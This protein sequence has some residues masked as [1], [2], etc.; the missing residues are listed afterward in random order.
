MKI[1]I[2]GTGNMGGAIIKGVLKKGI[3]KPDEIIGS[4]ISKEK[5][6]GLESFKIKTTQ[7]NLDVLD[8]ADGII[9]AVKPQ[10][11][12]PV[13]Q[14]IKNSV[15]GHHIISIAAGIK[16]AFIEERLSNAR[17]VRVMP[18]APLLVG[19]GISAIAKGR[20]TDS[21][22]I[23]FAKMVF[24]ALGDVIEVEEGLMN[25]VTSL[26]GSGPA[27]I[28]LIIDSLISVG[29]KM[30]LSR[31]IAERL[32]ISTISGSILMMKQTG[33]HPMELRDMVTS[34]GGTTAQAL[35]V[36]EVKGLPGILWEAIQAAEKRAEELS[37]G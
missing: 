35:E 12:D 26:S 22:D 36:M 11:M 15:K 2:I 13:L 3:F 29:V 25:A 9:L 14:E 18:N 7:N 23:G 27:Y 1:G 6:E 20:Y 31:D 17:V 28:F 24:G 5:L 16:T 33:K 32:V 21:S 19:C 37:I 30:G 4:D 34:P 8:F 10:V